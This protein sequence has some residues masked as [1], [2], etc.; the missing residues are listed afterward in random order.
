MA[1]GT[2]E[3]SEVTLEP[4]QGFVT[5]GPVR[6]LALE[7]EMEV[8]GA[9]ASEVQV[10]S[11]DVPVLIRAVE[12]TRVLVEGVDEVEPLRGLIPE[13]WEEVADSIEPGDVFVVLGG[14]DVGKS[15]LLTFLANR[16]TARGMTVALVDA[17]IGQS[18]V[19]PPGTIGLLLIDSPLIHPKLSEPSALF[20]VGDV[21]PRGHLLPM[22]VGSARLARLARERGADVTLVNTTGLIR[23]G[24][25]RALKRFKLAALGPTKVALIQREGEAEHLRRLIP[26]GARVVDMTPPPYASEKYRSLRRLSRRSAYARYLEGSTVTSYDLDEVGLLGTFLGSGRPRP[27]MVEPFSRSLGCRLLHLE[28]ASD[29]IVMV[30]E[31][32]PNLGA[33]KAIAELTGKEVRYTTP[34]RLRRLYVGL[35]DDDGLCVAVGLLERFDLESRFVRVRTKYYGVPD[36]IEFGYVRLNEKYEEV[37]RREPWEAQERGQ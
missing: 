30:C 18:D 19:G 2:E 29:A 5:H 33:L 25:A 20:F 21:T 11:P 24:A 6:L 1:L 28:E 37:G 9:P 12:R 34:E 36:R 17:D 7:G 27:D 31:G 15:G 13:S 14:V 22:V 23:G 8:W 35:L 26:R 3:G 10:D 32:R 16:L 4:G